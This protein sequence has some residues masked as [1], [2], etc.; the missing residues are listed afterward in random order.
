MA[1]T[2]TPGSATADSFVSVADCDAF[3]EARGLSD[4]TGAADSPADLKESAL[5]RATAFLSNAY[6]WKGVRTD[7]RSQAL[8]W[9]RDDVEDDEGE[10][11]ANDEIPVEIEQATCLIAA[12]EVVTPGYMS[13]AFT[14]SERIKRERVGQLEVEYLGGSMSAEAV[15]PVLLEVEDL[16]SGLIDG[17][18]GNA[19]VG[20][21]VRS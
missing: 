4:W 15:R 18:G 14:L 21:A 6:A 3:C 19:L 16:I 13:P 9:P 20:T 5:R 7:G 17:A 1:L 8:A 12:K 11:V 10:T 2:V